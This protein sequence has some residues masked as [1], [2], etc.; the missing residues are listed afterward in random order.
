MAPSLL[1]ADIAFLIGL[2]KGA[3]LAQKPTFTRADRGGVC[4]I[5]SW[6][7]GELAEAVMVRRMVRTPI[8]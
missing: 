1:E 4:C 3:W 5:F 2:K 6:E 7:V 8:R